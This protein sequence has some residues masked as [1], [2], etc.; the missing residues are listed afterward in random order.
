MSIVANTPT[1]LSKSSQEGILNFHNQ[2]VE[3][4]STLW[5][6]RT[7]LERNDRNYMREVDSTTEQQKAVIANAYGDTTKFQNI[8]VPVV[9]PQVEGAVVYQ[10][11]VFLTGNPIFESVASPEYQD[12]A[13]QLNA[14]IEEQQI[15]GGWVAQLMQHF[16]NGAKHNLAALEVDWKRVVTAALETDLGI[17]STQAI[18]KEIIWEGNSIR[19]LDLYNTFWD[20]RVDPVDVPAKGEFAG[21][22]ELMSR[23]ALKQFLNSLPYNT[24]VTAAF[25]STVGGNGHTYYTP[26]LNPN[27]FKS[28]KDM[29]GIAGSGMDWEA[30]VTASKSEVK[31]DYKN[32]YEVSTIYARII[33]SDFNIRVP[34]AGTPQVWKFIIVNHNVIVY[35]ERQTNAHGLIPI[36]FS[37]PNADGLGHQTK[38]LAEN[39]APFQSIA[40]AMWNSVIAA[41]RRAIS[42]RGIYDPSKIDAKHINS[43]NPAAKIPVRPS[44]YGKPVSDSYYPIPFRDDQSGILMQESQSVIQMANLVSGQNQVRQG[45]FVKGNKTRQEF[46]TVMGNA[47]GRDQSTSMLYESQLFTPLKEIIKLNILQYQGGT[48]I[49]NRE[50]NKVIEIDPIKLRKAITAFKMADGLLPTDK[51]INGD[52]LRQALQAISTSP[53]LNADY[54]V[55]QAFSYLMKTQGADLRPFEKSAEQ[56]AYE[57]ALQAWQGAVV[58]ALKNGATKDQLPPQPTPDQYGY[59]PSNQTAQPQEGGQAQAEQSTA[60]TQ[61]GQL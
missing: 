40:S 19:N 17:S 18:P 22:T 24:N 5:N 60:S 3:L 58:E 28:D 54:N 27:C 7:V 23:V 16:R 61:P 30:W 59:T 11:S 39:V 2:A 37:Q 31:I 35:S 15:R 29:Y 10:S 45:Q 55:G 51:L 46:D 41:R 53:Q 32:M 43:D 49:Y 47:N 8:V 34:Y 1:L 26:I 25:E 50:Q 56:K 14:V 57:Q 38:S 44:A 52:T 42:D 4:S 21:F 6:L 9:L 33:P 13:M 12:A 36:L 20:T 48:S